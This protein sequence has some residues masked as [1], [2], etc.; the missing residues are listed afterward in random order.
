MVV[1]SASSSALAQTTETCTTPVR[2]LFTCTTTTIEQRTEERT[3]QLPDEF[4]ETPLPNETERTPGT[5]PCEVGGSGRGG[6]TEGFY[7]QEFEVVSTQRYTVTST[8]T[9][10]I[11]ST[12]TSTQA[13]RGSKNNPQGAPI[14]T[15]PVVTETP[16]GT[17]TITRTPTGDPE[18]TRTPIGEPD[19]TATGRC[20]NVAGPQNEEAVENANPR[21]LEPRPRGNEEV[22]ENANP[23][24]LEPRPRGNQPSDLPRGNQPEDRLNEVLP[25]ERPKDELPE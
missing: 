23:R 22:V 17:P 14:V 13:Y 3:T 5:G 2:G 18:I 21:A 4:V 6:T 19:F 10:L 7:T 1:V 11:T 20:E 16:Q 9:F 12:T 15:G 8:Q 24:A 25:V